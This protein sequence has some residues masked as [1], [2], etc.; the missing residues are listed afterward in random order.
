MTNHMYGMFSFNSIFVKLFHLFLFQNIEYLDWSNVTI[1]ERGILHEMLFK[2]PEATKGRNKLF[3]F[4]QSHPDFKIPLTVP[5]CRL[6][7]KVD[8]ASTGIPINHHPNQAPTGIE[9]PN[10]FNQNGHHSLPPMRPEQ[11][12]AGKITDLNKTIYLRVF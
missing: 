10:T 6:P 2:E 3:E 4:L 1:A 11:G 5:H 9:T 12:S 7:D 8:G